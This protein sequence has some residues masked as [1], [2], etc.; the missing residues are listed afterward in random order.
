MTSVALLDA[1]VLYPAPIRDLLMQLARQGLYQPRWSADIHDEWT[2]S[3]LRDR[4]DL[5]ATQLSRTRALMD[6]HATGALVE[7][8]H[9]IISTLILPDPDD[10]H[11]LAAAI[12]G[13]ATLLVTFNTK[14]FPKPILDAHEISLID[15]DAFIEQ[16][17]MAEPTVA[18]A[19]AKAIVRRLRSPPMSAGDYLD[20]LARNR[21]VRTSA[22][23]CG[24]L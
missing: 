18:I 8:Y 6:Q 23:L 22:L 5:T 3:V 24:R 15:P 12:V 16:L 17:I 1:C 11:V 4:S 20:S 2:R 13:G 21:L 19:A 10:R 14:D 9:D 7:G